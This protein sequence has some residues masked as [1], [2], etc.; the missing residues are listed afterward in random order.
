MLG[1]SFATGIDHV[2]RDMVAQIHAGERVVD[3]STNK[4]LTNALS[5]GNM[6]G[7]TIN[8]NINAMDSQSVLGSL[9]SVKRELA[10]MLGGAS[11]NLNLAA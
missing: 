1:G 9:D 4:L 10:M 2:P 3:T 11:S 8:M 5:S 6:G 7:H